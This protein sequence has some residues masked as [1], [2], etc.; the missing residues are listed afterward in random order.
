MQMVRK[1][2]FVVALVLCA[3]LLG[4]GQVVADS[5]VSLLTLDE[6]ERLRFEDGTRI[7]TLRLRAAAKGPLI[8]VKLPQVTQSGTGSLIQT[9]TPTKLTV[10]FE[11]NLAPV[12]MSSLQVVAKK[13]IF[14]KS[15]TERLKPYVQGN[16][17]KVD[18][19][20]IPT[21]R[22][23]IQISIADLN[24][25]ATAQNYELVVQE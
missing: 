23:L 25:R 18:Q 1:D 20:E 9:A 21:G 5:G 12:D 19:V 16:S 3:H 17:L 24:G 13:G 4:P 2:L 8:E 15:L 10:L 11:R 7:P 14:S 22:F 6:A